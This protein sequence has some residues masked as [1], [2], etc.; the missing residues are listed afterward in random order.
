MGIIKLQLKPVEN[1]VLEGVYFD[2][3]NVSEVLEALGYE[4]PFGSGLFCIANDTLKVISLNNDINIGD[5]VTKHD[6]ILKKDLPLYQEVA[7]PTEKQE[8]ESK[9]W[10]V[11]T[12]DG[13]YLKKIVKGCGEAIADINLAKTYSHSH[14]MKLSKESIFT[15]VKVKKGVD[16]KLI[17][18]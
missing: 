13:L 12:E 17:I 6:V 14:A 18:A 10:V 8:S 2:G 3:V 1:P 4:K 7:A 16:G 9:L 11:R 15:A 5:F